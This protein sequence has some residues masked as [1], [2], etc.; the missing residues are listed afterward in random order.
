M[1]ALRRFRNPAI[2]RSARDPAGNLKP[3]RKSCRPASPANSRRCYD[4]EINVRISWVWDGGI[5]VWI[6]DDV[7]GY[8]AQ[9]GVPAAVEIL[10]WLQEAIAHFYPG[11]TYTKSLPDELLERG[12]KRM[13][14]PPLVGAEV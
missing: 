6:G 2:V 3:R 4:S 12:R 1:A 5:D 11:S 14:T 7:N 9:E 10:P 13:F 8:V